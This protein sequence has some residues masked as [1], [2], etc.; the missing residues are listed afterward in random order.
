MQTIILINGPS[1]SGK[2]LLT[3]FISKTLSGFITI[4]KKRIVYEIRNQINTEFFKGHLNEVVEITKGRI[5]NLDQLFLELGAQFDYIIDSNLSRIRSEIASVASTKFLQE[6]YYSRLYNAYAKE[7][8]YNQSENANFLIDENLHVHP[9]FQLNS[10]VECFRSY[11]IIK[12]C[13]Y[14]S[15]QQLLD[16]TKIRNIKFFK[17]IKTN[18]YSA[19]DINNQE[20]ESNGSEFN[21]RKPQ[22]IIDSFLKFFSVNQNIAPGATILETTSVKELL[23]VV[24]IILKVDNEHASILRGLGY[25]Y[26]NQDELN[27]IHIREKI[28]KKLGISDLDTN[29]YITARHPYDA[30]VPI[31]S[32]SC[33]NGLLDA[34]AISELLGTKLG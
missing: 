3:N 18:S 24:E 34:V 15:L 2:T 25:Y 9:P 8:E 30:I 14:N 13:I 19:F 5:A 10:F 27:S 28:I 33:S 20:I 17:F 6:T 12:V 4:N 7:I 32:I 23:N 26:Y 16:K 21:F 29:L 22:K 31:S 11:R 1:S